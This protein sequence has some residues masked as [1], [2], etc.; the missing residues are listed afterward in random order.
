M[1]KILLITL[2]VIISYAMN[3]QEFKV[4]S[5]ELDVLDSDGEPAALI[6]V[7]TTEEIS[8]TG[9]ITGIP[10]FDGTE[11]TVYTTKGAESLT[12]KVKGFPPVTYKFKEAIEPSYV[13]V[14]QINAIRP[15]RYELIIIPEISWHPSHTSYGLMVGALKIYGAY[16]KIKS[17]FNS[18]LPYSGICSDIGMLSNGSV[19]WFTGLSQKSRFS[20]SVGGLA[21]IRGPFTTYAGI[22]YGHRTLLWENYDHSYTKVSSSSTQGVEPEAGLMVKAGRVIL[23]AGISETGFKWA[24]GNIGIGMVF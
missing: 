15:E 17:D 16:L 14:M 23:T 2:A 21:H 13:Y 6:R 1:R 8:F 12:M 3:A 5:F 11:W 22:G 20:I 18:Q 10:S 4:K 7:R 19:G 24:E 9:P